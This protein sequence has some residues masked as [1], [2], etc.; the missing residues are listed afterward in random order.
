MSLPIEKLCPDC[1]VL[2]PAAEFYVIRN[3]SQLQTYCKPCQS[4]RNVVNYANCDKE[5]RTRLHRDW[6]SRNRERVAATKRLSAYGI[7]AAEFDCF[8]EKQNGGCAICKEPLNPANV[9]HDH[10][11]GTVRGLLCAGCNKGLG[12][13]DDNPK[14]LIRAASYIKPDIFAATYDP[15]EAFNSR[16]EGAS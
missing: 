3:G 2:K 5:E 14:L 16:D 8:M 15:V 7:S 11:S 12:F 13:F 4:K 6:V 9:D 10:N 1:S